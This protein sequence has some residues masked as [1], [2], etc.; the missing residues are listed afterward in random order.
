MAI[1]TAHLPERLSSD[2]LTS[3]FF[4]PF[5][6]RW[7]EGGLGARA[8]AACGVRPPPPALQKA[9]T[10]A[11]SRQRIEMKVCPK[12]SSAG[13]LRRL[14]RLPDECLCLRAHPK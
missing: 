3:S 8:A 11:V 13:S 5:S 1:S 12:R 10:A 6:S 2:G 14:L 7:S 4:T 9:E